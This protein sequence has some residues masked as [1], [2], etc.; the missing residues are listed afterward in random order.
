MDSLRAFRFLLMTFMLVVFGNRAA[1]ACLAGLLS[2]CAES[3]EDEDDGKDLLSSLVRM[4]REGL[5]GLVAREAWLWLNEFS[6]L[7]SKNALSGSSIL[8][9]T[10]N[11]PFRDGTLP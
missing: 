3:G 11:R 1:L 2:G 8:S 10:L 4:L 7:S 9:S 6:E 5:W